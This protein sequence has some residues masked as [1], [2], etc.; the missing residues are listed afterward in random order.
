MNEEKLKAYLKI[1]WIFPSPNIIKIEQNTIMQHSWE[2][3]NN[4][5]NILIHPNI[6]LNSLGNHILSVIIFQKIWFF[7]LKKH[8]VY[9]SPP[10]NISSMDWIGLKV[11]WF[12]LRFLW[13]QR[14]RIILCW[15]LK[16]KYYFNKNN[17]N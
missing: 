4:Y 9:Q 16:K 3:Q 13:K 17:L 1:F 12:G 15:I 14:R 5:R 7:G 2:Y 8:F 10:K 11:T 6:F